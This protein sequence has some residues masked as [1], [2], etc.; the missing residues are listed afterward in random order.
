[1]QE[2]QYS[3]VLRSRKIAAEELHMTPNVNKGIPMV[4]DIPEK[5]ALHDNVENFVPAVRSRY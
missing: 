1:L 3:R 2:V 5:F 4:P